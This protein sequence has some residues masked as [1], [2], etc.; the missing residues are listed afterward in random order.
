MKKLMKTAS[1]IIQQELHRYYA[2]LQIVTGYGHQLDIDLEKT[3]DNYSDDGAR[4]IDEQENSPLFE[5]LLGY[6]FR[7]VASSSSEHASG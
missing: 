4:T 2:V 3:L 1:R 5:K 7:I 6:V